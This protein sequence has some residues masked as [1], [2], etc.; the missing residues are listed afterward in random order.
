MPCCASIKQVNM[1]FSINLASGLYLKYIKLSFIPDVGCMCMLLHR[2]GLQISVIQGK[3][4]SLNGMTCLV[5]FDAILK[6]V[7][8][9]KMDSRFSCIPTF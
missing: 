9:I 1:H 4:Y 8:L 3:W 5:M 7:P 2:T 6:S